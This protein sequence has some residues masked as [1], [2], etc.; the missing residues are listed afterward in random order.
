L[1]LVGYILEYRHG[2][3][4]VWNSTLLRLF[5][6]RCYQNT[7]TI[8]CYNYFQDLFLKSDLL[9]A[10]IMMPEW[11]IYWEVT[12]N[13][14]YGYGKKK[15]KLHSGQRQRF[16][17]E[18]R[19]NFITRTVEFINYSKRSAVKS[20][21]NSVILYNEE[22]GRLVQNYRIKFTKNT[23]RHLVLGGNCVATTGENV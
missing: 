20:L 14:I 23:R 1:H 10:S 21:H 15:I 12:D 18:K 4:H 16:D 5:L 22:M 13:N 9:H 19:V 3:F 7:S 17:A 6:H 2:N 11:N 8:H